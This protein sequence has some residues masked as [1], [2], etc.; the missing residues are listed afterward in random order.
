MDTI[1]C[2]CGAWARSASLRQTGKGRRLAGGS[3]VSH[4]CPACERRW[5][6]FAP[7]LCPND[8][9]TTMSD[10]G[11]P[12]LI[13][14]PE[15]IFRGGGCDDITGLKIDH[16]DTICIGGPDDRPG[17]IQRGNVTLHE[18]PEHWNEPAIKKQKTVIGGAGKQWVTNRD[19]REHGNYGW[20]QP[21]RGLDMAEEALAT[22]ERAAGVKTVD[23][24]ICNDNGMNGGCWDCGRVFTSDVRTVLA[25]RVECGDFAFHLVTPDTGACRSV[26]S[27]PPND[28]LRVYVSFQHTYDKTP[29]QLR[30]HLEQHHA[31]Q[32]NTL[33]FVLV[34]EPRPG[35]PSLAR[36]TLNYD[37]WFGGYTAL[38]QIAIYHQD[39]GLPKD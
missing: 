24:P 28:E 30:I 5:S 20:H 34:D 4:R 23:C 36:L 19:N 9:V 3:T 12:V 2:Q 11:Q 13:K 8:I 18:P 21:V 27:G 22:A 7:D 31:H 39:D 37:K 15:I 33:A 38:V 17:G 16:S 10:M 35:A 1:K 29:P 14:E 32:R 25:R 26:F 6:S